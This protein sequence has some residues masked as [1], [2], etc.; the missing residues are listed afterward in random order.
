M[1][2]LSNAVKYNRPGGRIVVDAEPTDNGMLR[3]SVA[4]TGPGIAEQDLGE[5]FE[6]FTRLKPSSHGDIEGS[7]IGL[8]ITKR[9]VEMMGGRIGLQ[10]ALGQ[11][12]LFWIELPLAKSDGAAPKVTAAPTAAAA[13]PDAERTA[14]LVNRFV[15]ED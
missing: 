1:N 6:P 8:T 15:A 7:G 9:L 11:G 2:L 10:S 13:E 5:I 12:S 14:E 4:D 3:L